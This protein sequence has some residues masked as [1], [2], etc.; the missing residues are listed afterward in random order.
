M[1]EMNEAAAILSGATDRSLVL[2]DEIGRGTST[3]DGV[4]IAWA[5]TEH[6]HEK[7]GAKTIF[8]THYHELTQLGDQLG[9]VKNMTVT[10][11]EA[12]EEILFL[13]RLESGG[14][15]GPTGSRLLALRGFPRRSSSAPSSSSPSSRGAMRGAERASGG[16]AAAVRP[17]PL[18]SSSSPSS[19][20]SIR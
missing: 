17:R 4:S 8:A 18:A 20:S 2:L 16:A 14:R 1:V 6:L 11:R 13:R 9:G 19:P 5:M 3:Y 7:V 10:V 12:G 15:T